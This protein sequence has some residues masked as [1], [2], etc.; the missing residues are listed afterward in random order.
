MEL[1]V[2]DRDEP[3]HSQFPHLSSS[4]LDLSCNVED[5]KYR[6][7]DA[8]SLGSFQPFYS[9]PVKKRRVPSACIPCKLSRAKCS[10]ARPCSRCVH[11]K[12]SESCIDGPQNAKVAFDS[13]L[14]FVFACP[15]YLQADIRFQ[16]RHIST[17]D[18]NSKLAQKL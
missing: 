13:C 12:R 5:E 1:K 4:I 18:K 7:Q 3:N 17:A 8:L 9:R 10:D 16:N 14:T 11:N 15:L 6:F 2:A